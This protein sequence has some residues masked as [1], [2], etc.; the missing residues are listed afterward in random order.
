MILTYGKCFPPAKL[1]K[2]YVKKIISKKT[3][4]SIEADK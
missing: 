2:I 1:P 4:Q 3:I